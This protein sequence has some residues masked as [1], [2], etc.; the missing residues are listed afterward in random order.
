M[1]KEKGTTQRNTLYSPSY[2]VVL[3]FSCKSDVPEAILTC[4][5][6]MLSS[7]CIFMV[8]MLNRVVEI[9]RRHVGNKETRCHYFATD[10][11]HSL[12]LLRIFHDK[13]NEISRCEILFY[14]MFHGLL[15]FSSDVNFKS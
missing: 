14:G 13:N 1:Q 5:H 12:N 15:C 9:D 6:L 2:S 8:L 3:D 10:I 4:C 7:R 11:K